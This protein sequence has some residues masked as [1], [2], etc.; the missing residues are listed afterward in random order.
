MLHAGG[1]SNE[2]ITTSFSQYEVITDLTNTYN[3]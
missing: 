1:V 2:R 3:I